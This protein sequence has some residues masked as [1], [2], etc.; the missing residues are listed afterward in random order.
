MLGTAIIVF[1]ETLEAA[2][3]VSIVLA[4]TRGI[5]G[6]RRWIGAGVLC[7]IAGALIIAG[8]AERIAG[9]L[10]G[11]GQE[12]FDAAILIAAVMMLAWHHL[13]MVS[14][15]RALAAR[16]K[17]LGD[18][19]REG[20]GTLAAL[21][22]AVALAVLREGAETVLF[23]QGIATSAPLREVLAGLASGVT[24]GAALGSLLYLGLVHVPVRHFFRVTGWLIVALAAG[25]AA[26][27]ARFL[28]QANLLP[29]IVPELW[30]TSAILSAASLPGQLLHILVGYTPT[31]SGLQF[32][33]YAVTAIGLIVAARWRGGTNRFSAARA[34]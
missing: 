25:L 7:G 14:H 18:S 24:G 28:E 3:I 4:A 32:A 20:G 23:L 5:A 34:S 1:R 22:A 10:Q 8:M 9:A 19:V 21:S 31:P 6:R 29:P 26:Q 13:W 33:C 30:D 2:L 27:A 16:L 12:V 11:I 17:A 15:G